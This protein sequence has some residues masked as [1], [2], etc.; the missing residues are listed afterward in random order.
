MQVKAG[1]PRGEGE[2]RPSSVP[3]LLG[4]LG[5]ACSI[6]P[7]PTRWA[8]SPLVP[9]SRTT[10]PSAGAKLVARLAFSKI[11]ELQG[12]LAQYQQ[13]LEGRGAEVA[14]LEGTVA[15]LQAAA[16]QREAAVAAAED[17][18]AQVPRS[19]AVVR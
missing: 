2:R 10:A 14:A 7:H 12:S 4:R 3:L 11:K 19:A 5:N 18:L 6:P 17:R 8:S 9:K 16:S 15:G 1:T 13:Q